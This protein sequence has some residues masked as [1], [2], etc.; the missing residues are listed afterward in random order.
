MD[1]YLIKVVREASNDPITGIFLK[2]EEET[3]TISATSEHEAYKQS[4]KK[5]NIL[6]KGQMRKTFINGNE[7]FNPRF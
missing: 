7:Y 3:L 5:S 6:F 2:G 1:T 4:L